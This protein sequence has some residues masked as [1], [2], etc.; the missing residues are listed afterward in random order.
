MNF[1]KI[2]QKDKNMEKCSSWCFFL[3]AVLVFFAICAGMLLLSRAFVVPGS[4]G[5]ARGWLLIPGFAI[6]GVLIFLVADWIYRYGVDGSRGWERRRLTFLAA[7]SGLLVL[8]VIAIIIW[9]SPDAFFQNALGFSSGDATA[10][11][12]TAGG[13]WLAG[14]GIVIAC[15]AWWR[16]WIAGW[17]VVIISALLLTIPLAIYMSGWGRPA[18]SGF[19]HSGDYVIL[20]VGCLIILGLVMWALFSEFGRGVVTSNAPAQGVIPVTFY[21]PEMFR[22]AWPTGEAK[23][24]S[25]TR[26]GKLCGIGMVN[27]YTT[28]TGTRRIPGSATAAPAREMVDVKTVARSEAMTGVSERNNVRFTLG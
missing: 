4:D 9:A 7:L 25:D 22:T 14:L 13:V 1:I 23:G 11:Q 21:K 15:W 17:V 10:A 19:P 16:N 2:Y 5:S 27:S 18:G 28:F 20:V 26:D 6:L 8:S 12:Y 3:T 24:I